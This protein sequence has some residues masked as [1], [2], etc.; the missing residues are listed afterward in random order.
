M[1]LQPAGYEPKTTKDPK[2]C[3][4]SKLLNL[5]PLKLLPFDQYINHFAKMRKETVAIWLLGGNVDV[6][7]SSLVNIRILISYIRKRVSHL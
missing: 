2:S 5:Q 1:N 7:I 4:D 6:K 3:S